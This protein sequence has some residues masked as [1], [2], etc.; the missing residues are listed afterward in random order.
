MFIENLQCI[1]NALDMF[2]YT[3]RRK[4]RWDNESLWGLNNFSRC[5][6]LELECKLMTETPRVLFKSQTFFNVQVLFSPRNILNS[7]LSLPRNLALITNDHRDWHSVLDELF[8]RVLKLSTVFF[9]ILKALVAKKYAYLTVSL[10]GDVMRNIQRNKQIHRMVVY[11]FTIIKIFE[12][13]FEFQIIY[14]QNGHTPNEIWFCRLFWGVDSSCKLDSYVV[15]TKNRNTNFQS[16]KFKRMST[17]SLS[18]F[19]PK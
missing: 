1:G 3:Q 16:I 11:Y 12:L 9:V 5:K 4:Y 7:V 8:L 2:G 10:V 18:R 15:I 14:L 13:V 19:V 17:L 6:A